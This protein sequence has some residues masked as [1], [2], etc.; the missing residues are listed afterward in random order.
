MSATMSAQKT[1]VTM[2]MTS[3]AV[4]KP[5]DEYFS[6]CATPMALRMSPTMGTTKTEPPHSEMRES[7][8][9]A[10]PKALIGFLF[11]G[12]ILAPQLGQSAASAATSLPQFLQ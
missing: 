6:R 12:S 8:K 9:P 3:P 5:F 2:L 7:T 10:M 4:A 11:C 1:S